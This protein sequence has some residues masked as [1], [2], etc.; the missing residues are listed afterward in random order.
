[1]EKVKD[2]APKSPHSCGPNTVTV[3]LSGDLEIEKVTYKQQS[4]RCL[5]S[6]SVL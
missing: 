3:I 2:T 4:I 5:R 6:H 1:M